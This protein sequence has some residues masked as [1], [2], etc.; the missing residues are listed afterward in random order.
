MS[1]LTAGDDRSNSLPIAS[2]GAHHDGSGLYVPTQTPDLGDVVPIRVRVPRGTGV[3]SV[4]IR[5]VQDA[6]PMY[7][8]AVPDG[9]DEY[10]SWFT[11]EL[12]VHNPI[13]SY[14]VLIDRASAGY[15]WLNGT[16]E[17]FR[18]IADLHDFRL[19]VYPPGPDWALDSVVYQVF[20]DRFA[21]SDAVREKPPWALAAGWEDEVIHHGPDTPRQFFGGDLD[22]IRQHLDHLAELGANLLYLTP[23]FPAKSNHR[24]NASSFNHVDPLLGGDD[25]LIRLAQEVHRRGMRIVGDLTTNHSGDDHHWFT[26]ALSDP[27]ADERRFYYVADDGSYAA[28]LGHASLPKFDL[29]SPELRDRMFGQ[30][31]STVARWLR[32]P[33]DLD[34]W[35][36]DVANMTG[37]YGQHDHA[38][39][40]ARE[41]RATMDAVRPDSVLLAEHCHDATGDL[42]GEGWQGT[43]NYAGFTRPVWSWLT[44]SD[45]GLGFLGMPV[46]VPRRPGLATMTTMRDFAASVPWKVACRN[47]NLL[48]SHD[49]PRIRTLT[50]SRELVAVA[51]GLQ[52]THI[53]SPMIFA[54]EE[55]GFEGVDGEDSRRP[56]PWQRRD[57]W[58]NETFTVFKDLIALRQS[59]PALRRGGLRWMIATDDALGYLRETVDERIL[60]V[61]SRAPWS[62]ALLPNWLCGDGTPQ[63]LYGASDLRVTGGALVV[64]GDGPFIGVWRLA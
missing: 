23:I 9:G 54:G 57:G 20:P 6:E 43:M 63:I 24:Y 55:L 5:V 38:N 62:G 18:D 8:P 45:N 64:P 16:G 3:D 39:S 41:I 28:W 31:D 37:R 21:K 13:T 10:E 2:P 27:Q 40:V 52:M 1:V 22:G 60:V 4:F 47:W 42:T 26:T 50:G 53:G 15:S 14:R 11:A 59:H 44:S 32:D 48:G 7:V 58:D 33:F 29:E 25:G 12:P 34:G 51:A 30:Q 35:R 56:I 19:T 17:Y 46:G 49:T 36:I 61:A